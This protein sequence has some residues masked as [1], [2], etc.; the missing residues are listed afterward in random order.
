MRLLPTRHDHGVGGI[1]Q[2]KSKTERYRHLHGDHQHMSLRHLQ[3][4][5]RC[6]SSRRRWRRD[7]RLREETMTMLDVSR[8][9]FLA[10]STAAGLSVGFHVPFINGAAAQETAP[11]I[12]AWV[13]I[14]PDE[15]VL[16]RVAR[17]E[18]GQGTLTGLAQVVAEE[19]AC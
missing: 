3:P 15:A 5:A 6:H 16:I 4:S 1:A 13:V 7:P 14:K 17:S 18:M 9:N 11:E 2:A 19:L 12:N 8:R 10:G